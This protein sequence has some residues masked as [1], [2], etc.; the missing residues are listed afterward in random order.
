MADFRSNQR[1][2]HRALAA[3]FS[4]YR[5]KR[6][7]WKSHI[8]VSHDGYNQTSTLFLEVVV[9]C[10]VVVVFVVATVFVV[11]VALVIITL[12]CCYVVV[13]ALVVPFVM[14]LC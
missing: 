11:I 9:V 3:V 4:H 1:L 13:A 7:W 6:Y 8:D 12:L 10:V 14:V 2:Y 5:P